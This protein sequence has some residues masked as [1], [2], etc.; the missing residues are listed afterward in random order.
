LAVGAGATSFEG[1]ADF[2]TNLSADR[3]V[4]A[5]GYLSVLVSI[6]L[7]LGITQLLA[8]FSRWLE[9]RAT[10]RAYGPAIA[11]AVLLLLAHIQT[12]W[13]MYG[14]RL[15]ADW[16]FLQFFMVL[17]QPILLFLLATLVLPG[18]SVNEQDLRSNFIAQRPW[19][20]GLFI[21]LLVVSLVRDLVRDGTLPG[22]ANLGFHG[23]LFLVGATAALTRNERAQHALAYAALTLFLVYTAVLFADLA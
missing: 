23:T 16:T 17:L 6:V 20:F 7:G 11:W 2:S 21:A 5:F 8:G 12:W 18:A 10:F 14:L 1:A 4:D 22:A 3:I 9:R 19:F 15:Y 13:S